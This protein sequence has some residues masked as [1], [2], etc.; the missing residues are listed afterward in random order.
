MIKYIEKPMSKK[1]K[2]ITG[3]KYGLLTAVEYKG[4]TPKGDAVWRFKC[5]CGGEKI[6]QI[7]NVAQ[8]KTRSCGCL[9]KYNTR[10]CKPNKFIIKG[11]LCIMHVYRADGN[12]RATVRLD[13]EDYDKVKDYQN[14]KVLCT[15]CGVQVAYGNLPRHRNSRRHQAMK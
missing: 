8:G 6:V 7:R 13:S 15:L 11:N 4:S 2:D 10:P 3:E 5:T 14:K 1:V 9:Y 12:H